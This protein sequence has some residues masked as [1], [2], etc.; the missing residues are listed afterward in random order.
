M[1]KVN[2]SICVSSVIHSALLGFVELCH[3]SQ[4]VPATIRWQG[5][6]LDKKNNSSWGGGVD[7]QETSF[8]DIIA[9][10]SLTHRVVVSVVCF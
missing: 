3:I 1:F 7:F 9:K 2:L 10:R 6:Y 4:S 8:G 5:M